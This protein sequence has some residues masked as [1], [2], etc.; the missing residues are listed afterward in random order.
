MEENEKPKTEQMYLILTPDGLG[1]VPLKEATT[2]SYIRETVMNLDQEM[3]N[4]LRKGAEG[5]Q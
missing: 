1:R 3:R 4:Y 2:I 5:T